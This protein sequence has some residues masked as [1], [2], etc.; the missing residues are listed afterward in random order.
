LIGASIGDLAEHG[1]SELVRTFPV[2]EFAD[3]S[4]VFR[5]GDPGDWL[6]VV[7]EGEAV[8]EKTIDVD[9]GS[10]EVVAMVARDDLIGEMSFLDRRPRSATV[11]ARG[12]LRLARLSATEFRALMISD[13]DVAEGLI[14]V[15][16]STLSTRLRNSTDALIALYQA[17]RQIGM[18]ATVE[19][20]S[21]CVLQQIVK[22]VPAATAGVV[23][24][25]DD[26]TDPGGVGACRPVVG[27]GLPPGLPV[28]FPLDLQG[29]LFR[30]LV[31]HPVGML[32]GPGDPLAPEVSFLEAR[33]CLLT[34]LVHGGLPL[35]LIALCSSEERS[36]FLPSH[37]VALAV[38]ANQAAAAIARHLSTRYR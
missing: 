4:I 36:P 17:G 32:I 37:Q 30:A 16:L 27:F 33:W 35:G 9:A 13:P 21:A 38:L 2:A 31:A 18:A 12:R 1:R 26:G 11:R 22:V 28:P 15:L 19:D 24:T 5:E 6:G 3:G 10:V 14:G 20:L 7:L 23:A 29:P 25:L 34:E 8:V